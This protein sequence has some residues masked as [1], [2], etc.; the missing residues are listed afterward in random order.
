LLFELLQVLH[1]VSYGEVGRV[2]LPVVAVL[3]P[4]L[5]GFDV[6]RLER[7]ALVSKPFE[8]TVNQVLVF[9][10]QATKEQGRMLPLALYEEILHRPSEMLPRLQLDAQFVR[11]S[12]ALLLELLFDQF[13]LGRYVHQGSIAARWLLKTRGHRFTSLTLLVVTQIKIRKSLQG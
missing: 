1:Q 12:I 7:L 9:P 8:S 13:F 2:A 11:K 3:L 10:G 5:K 4:E 6:R